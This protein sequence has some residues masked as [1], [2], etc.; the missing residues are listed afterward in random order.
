MYIVIGNS[1]KKIL[2]KDLNDCIYYKQQKAFTDAQY[3]HSNELKQ[4]IGRGFVVVVR[5]SEDKSTSFNISSK[6]AIPEIKDVGVDSSKVDQLLDRIKELEASLDK[7]DKKDRDVIPEN[8]DVGVDSSKVDQL[9]D[10]IKELE[11]SLDKQSKKDKDRDFTL[12]SAILERLD[13]LE[14]KES[15][16]GI[17]EVKEV[18]GNIEKKIEDNNKQGNNND[19]L[20]EKLQRIINTSFNST[21]K[22]FSPK[23]VD[24]T[25]SEERYI[26]NIRVED[27]KS[28]INLQVREIDSG[29]NVTDSI[30]KLKELRS[31]SK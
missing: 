13:N 12:L 2:L 28:H 6:D 25:I 9:L 4:A 22:E 16:V 24:N 1:P 5:R 11:V 27:A 8:K 23:K 20:I 14:K 29:D 21:N 17:S 10:R 18:L 26:P 31:K 15:T 30:R 3:R 19:V 7:Q